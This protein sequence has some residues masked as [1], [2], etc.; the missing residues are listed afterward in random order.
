MCVCV[1]VSSVVCWVGKGREGGGDD[2]VPARAHECVLTIHQ[3]GTA[4]AEILSTQPSNALSFNRCCT[5]GGFYAS[6]NYSR[7]RRQLP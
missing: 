6:Y 7:A 5:F 4:N 2:G 3:M 1:C